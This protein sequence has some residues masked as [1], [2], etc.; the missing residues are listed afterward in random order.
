MGFMDKIK[1]RK[2]DDLLGGD[3]SLGGSGSFVA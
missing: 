1:G 2:D 3:D